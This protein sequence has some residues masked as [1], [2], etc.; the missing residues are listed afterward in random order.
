MS[1]KPKDNKPK[2]LAEMEE[3]LKQAEQEQKHL[4]QKPFMAYPLQEGFGWAVND[5][6]NESQKK[7]LASFDEQKKREEQ[8]RAEVLASEQKDTGTN[9]AKTTPQLS[10]TEEFRRRFMLEDCKNNKELAAF[11]EANPTYITMSRGIFDNPKDFPFFIGKDM[12]FPMH[13]VKGITIENMEDPKD[14]YNRVKLRYLCLNPNPVSIVPFT[15]DPITGLQ[16]ILQACRES[17]EKATIASEL[18]ETQERV[19]QVIKYLK[20]WGNTNYDTQNSH[21]TCRV[22]GDAEQYMGVY[23]KCLDYRLSILAGGYILQPVQLVIEEIELQGKEDSA[24]RIEKHLNDLKQC[25]KEYDKNLDPNDLWLLPALGEKERALKL[26]QLLE[27]ALPYLGLAS[28]K[29]NGEKG[30]SQPPNDLIKSCV[31]VKKFSV[32]RAT[33]KRAVKDKKL[34]SYRPPRAP[35]NSPHLFSEKEIA[36]LWPSR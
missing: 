6:P 27:G 34:K 17:D 25:V 20:F 28:T 8:K 32:S 2:T 23:G 16:N 3:I 30:K 35:R 13:G 24:R 19:K 36:A 10:P 33:L 1:R 22:Y 14:L 9:A 18:N 26:A 4:E 15:D 5:P 12:D 21:S 7:L 11:I 29:Q 31:A